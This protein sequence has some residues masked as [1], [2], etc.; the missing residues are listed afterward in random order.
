MQLR[1]ARA[2]DRWGVDERSGMLLAE[3][4]LELL[5]GHL[6]GA[7]SAEESAALERRV[8]GAGHLAGALDALRAHRAER[9]AVWAALEPAEQEVERCVAAVMAGIRKPRVNWSRWRASA[10][11]AACVA[12]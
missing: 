2:I 12:I 1:R 6:D 9:R 4:E 3:H 10:A 5:E 8:C 11:I 7:L